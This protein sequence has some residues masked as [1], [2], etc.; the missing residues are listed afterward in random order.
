MV[1]ADDFTA[2]VPGIKGKGRYDYQVNY[3][4]GSGI[5][6]TAVGCNGN[7]DGDVIIFRDPPRAF[8]ISANACK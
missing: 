6:I 8:E 5:T 4:R 7:V 1:L 2:M 3:V